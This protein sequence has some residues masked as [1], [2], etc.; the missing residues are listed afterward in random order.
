MRHRACMQHLLCM[1]TPVRFGVADGAID[2]TSAAVGKVSDQGPTL[3]KPC[4]AEA[5][6]IWVLGR[7]KKPLARRVDAASP[8]V[9]YPYRRSAGAAFALSLRKRREPNLPRG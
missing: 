6:T 2:V 4:S 8:A 9:R 5:L 1:R 3:R 7:P